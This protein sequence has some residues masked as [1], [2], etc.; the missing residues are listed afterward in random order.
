LA[1]TIK[2]KGISVAEGKG[3]WHGKALNTTELEQAVS[4]IAK[5]IDRENANRA[6]VD[7]VSRI[8]K[9]AA[10]SRPAIA[11]RPVTPPAYNIGDEVATREAY[12]TAIAKLG[13]ADPRVVALDADVKNSTFSDKFANAIPARFHEAFI[14]EQAMVGAAMGLAARG[15][16]PFPSTFAC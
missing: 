16:I 13:D 3:G 11:P 8:E 6:P 4:E 10:R 1:R 5:E 7:L 14:A 12:G 2:G 15:A 9:P